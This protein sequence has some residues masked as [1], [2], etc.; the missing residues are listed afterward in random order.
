M[1]LQEVSLT[2]TVKSLSQQEFYLIEVIAV[3]L[4][5]LKNRL[6]SLEELS[7]GLTEAM[8]AADFDW[9]ITVPAMWKTR[10]KQMMREAAYLVS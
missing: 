5:H 8:K 6:L 3:T 10:G 7:R 1:A 9:V 4:R 2:N